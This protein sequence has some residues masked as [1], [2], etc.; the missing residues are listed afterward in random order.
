M[1][2]LSGSYSR[3]DRDKAMAG[4]FQVLWGKKGDENGCT[5]GAP[6]V[7]N[8]TDGEPLIIQASEED[9][10]DRICTRPT[11]VDLNG[12]G[13]LDIVTGNFRGTFALFLGE[14]EGKFSP[15]HQ[16]LMQGG[17]R[18]LVSEHS[19]PWFVDWDQDGDLDLLSGSSD[20]GVF[21]FSN[22]GSK[23]KPEFVE[24]KTILAAVGHSRGEMVFGEAHIQGPQTSTRVC[25]DDVNGDGKLDILIG[26]RVYLTFPAKGLDEAASRR[27]LATWEARS[28]KA[29]KAMKQAQEE[30]PEAEMTDEIK[31]WNA[32][33]KERAKILTQEATGFVWVMY[34]K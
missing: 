13:K 22:Q 14:G 33:Y 15:K 3:M 23:S 17:S 24:P 27:E 11:A 29:Q 21:L 7:L 34:Q 31:A 28:A 5:F 2:I 10:V 8:G 1:D 20:G 4:L 6:A 32:L 19:D 9:D 12:D 30:S 16:W 18:L 26:D 25:T